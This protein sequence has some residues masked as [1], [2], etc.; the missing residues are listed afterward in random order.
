MIQKILKRLLT[1]ICAFIALLFLA[2]AIF[3]TVD[4]TVY[5][6]AWFGLLMLVVPITLLFCPLNGLVDQVRS[7]LPRT[8]SETSNSKKAEEES[9]QGVSRVDLIHRLEKS[10]EYRIMLQDYQK[11]LRQREQALN[12]RE[13]KISEIEKS[14]IQKEREIKSKVRDRVLCEVRE[15]KE[16]LERKSDLLKEY[17]KGLRKTEFT[18][19]DWLKR[20]DQKERAIFDDLLVDAHRYEQYQKEMPK[21]DGFQFEEYVASLMVASGYENVKVTQKSGDFGADIVAEKQ[22]VKYV[23]QCKYYTSQVGI[24]SV[25][26]IY[27]AK[28][29]YDAHVAIVAT[30][31]VFTKAAQT[32]ATN[33][34]VVLW[35][36]EDIIKMANAK[37]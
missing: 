3:H 8:S 14:L 26:Q 37:R 5:V 16:N 9:R 21:M 29:H 36:G 17:E 31:S 35:D 23:V 11:E 28:I 24:E 34:G 32:L 1:S 20:I 27:A 30:N 25:Q 4:E 18:L 10:R 22:D 15:E 12:E 13:E 7:F 19:L 2:N 33:V 6:P